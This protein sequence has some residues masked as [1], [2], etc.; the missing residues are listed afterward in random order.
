MNTDSYMYGR[1]GR[2]CINLLDVIRNDLTSR[3]L[4]IKLKKLTDF[5]DL[6]FLAA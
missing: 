4:N 1:S 5:I 2:P 3:N 6:R